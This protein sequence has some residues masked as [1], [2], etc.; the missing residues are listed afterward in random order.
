MVVTVA[1]CDWREHAVVATASTE[2]RAPA[3]ALLQKHF[4]IS[5]MPRPADGSAFQAAMIRHYPADLLAHRVT[6]DVLLDVSL[7]EHGV[8]RHVAV[9]TPPRTSA[10]KVHRALLVDRVPGANST[11]TREYDPT[12]DPR[13]APAA[14]A[15]MRETRFLPA[16]R[17]GRPVPFTFRM[18]LRFSPPPES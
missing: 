5:H 16:L 15:A 6:G 12:Y 4:R 2:V 17:G 13:F 1:A 7:D 9:A 10:G 3:P 11:T 14:L 8:V 18:S